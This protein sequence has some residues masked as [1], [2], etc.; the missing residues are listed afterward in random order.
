LF[1]YAVSAIR[2][3]CRPLI[4]ISVFFY[5]K[6]LCT[7]L[8]WFTRETRTSHSRLCFIR[9]V[10]GALVN[11]RES[12]SGTSY[13]TGSH[14]A[15]CMMCLQI[16]V[17]LRGTHR[18]YRAGSKRRVLFT[19]HT[20][21]E[22]RSQRQHGLKTRTVISHYHWR[23]RCLCVLILCAGSDLA[24]GRSP[25]QGVLQT[26]KQTKKLTTVKLV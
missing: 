15:K 23:Q 4:Y 25:V 24:T 22:R 26:N 9:H 1:I 13:E 8:L 16:L 6:A 14:C 7:R 17:L 10:C 3:S 19:F 5:G 12:G 2:R 20:H 21:R 18:V 11:K